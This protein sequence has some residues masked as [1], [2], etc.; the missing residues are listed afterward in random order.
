M[1]ERAVLCSMVESPNRLKTNKAQLSVA[2][3]AMLVYS[4]RPVVRSSGV[5]VAHPAVTAWI[6][7]GGGRP[8]APS[9]GE[10]VVATLPTLLELRDVVAATE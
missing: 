1:G 2:Q 5:F 3:R 7:R 4:S 8:T 6:M 9:R 10:G